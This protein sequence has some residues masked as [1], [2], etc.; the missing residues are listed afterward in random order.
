MIVI[1][2]INNNVVL[3]QDENGKQKILTGMG[4]GFAAIPGS[5][6]REDSIEHTFILMENSNL[7]YLLPLLKDIL[8]DILSACDEIS[9][10]AERKLNK[11]RSPNLPITLAD[12]IY[13]ATKRSPIRHLW[14]EEIGVFY[15]EE[16]SFS[17]EVLIFLE[18]NYQIDLDSNE[19]YFL[20][21]HFINAQMDNEG[22]FISMAMTESIVHIIHIIE[23]HYNIDISKETIAFSRFVTHFRFYL[24]RLLRENSDQSTDEGIVKVVQESYPEEFE[25]AN[26]ITEYLDN[27]YMKGSNDNERVYLALHIRRILEETND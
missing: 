19:A 3:V 24:A 5:K 23:K 18:E 8:F 4:L 7:E 22:D 25:C 20:T 14:E 1:N 2:K 6:V 15:P 21:L 27:T 12:H 10:L 11:K 13:M 26:K 17:K 9:F 16:L